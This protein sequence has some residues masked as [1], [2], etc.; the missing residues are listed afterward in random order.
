MLHC[1]CTYCITLKFSLTPTLDKSDIRPNIVAMGFPS[2]KFEGVIRNNMQ[3]VI[4]YGY[5]YESYWLILLSLFCRMFD[6]KYPDRYKVYNLC[7]ERSYDPAKFHHRGES[8]VVIWY[9]KR[10][11]FLYCVLIINVQ[12][13]PSV[14]L[15]IQ[16]F[17]HNLVLPIILFLLQNY[18]DLIVTCIIMIMLSVIT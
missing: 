11:I 1:V 4:R 2:E 3:D 9:F 7:S 8:H 5:N 15:Y 16:K 14:Y 12:Q 13:I 10:N 17:S 6:R 18:W